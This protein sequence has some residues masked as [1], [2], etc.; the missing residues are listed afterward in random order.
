[1]QIV[2]TDLVGPLPESDNRNKYIL[3]GTDYFTRWVEAFSLPSQEVATKLID[4]VFL[5]F[6]VPEQL[7]SDQGR[8]FKA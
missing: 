7:Y 1:M 8:Q 6:C 4:E 5:Q 3:V 2:A